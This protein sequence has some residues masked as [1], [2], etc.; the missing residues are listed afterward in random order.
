MIGN[1]ITSQLTVICCSHHCTMLQCLKLCSQTPALL[2]GPQLP[3]GLSTPVRK[4]NLSPSCR[5]NTPPTHQS[6]TTTSGTCTSRGSEEVIILCERRGLYSSL[7]HGRRDQ[8]FLSKTRL[9]RKWCFMT[10]TA[11]QQKH[12]LLLQIP[13]QKS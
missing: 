2:A 13:T 8:H 11:K 1:H 9:N 12:K 3:N 10:A 5:R 7:T 4:V 6:E